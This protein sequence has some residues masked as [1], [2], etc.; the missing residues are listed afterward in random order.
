MYFLTTV[1]PK[2]CTL[3]KVKR[4][5]QKQEIFSYGDWELPRLPLIPATDVIRNREVKHHV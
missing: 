3:L 5:S 4:T 1:L 2:M